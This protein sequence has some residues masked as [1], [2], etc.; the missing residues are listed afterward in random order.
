MSSNRRATLR[1]ASAT[2]ALLTLLATGSVE[3]FASL[4]P[5]RKWLKLIVPG[6][7]R[8]SS[9]W[10]GPAVCG[11]PSGNALLLKGVA[12]GPWATWRLSAAPGKGPGPSQDL[13]A[14]VP[15]VFQIEGRTIPLPKCGT[16]LGR[17]SCPSYL[18]TFPVC[19]NTSLSMAPTNGSMSQFVLERVVGTAGQ[20]YVRVNARGAGC[21]KRY[22]GASIKATRRGCKE[23]QL[24]LFAKDEAST[25]TRWQIIDR[26]ALPPCASPPSPPRPSPPPPRPSPPPPHPSPPPPSPSPPSPSPP[27]PSPSPPPPSPSPPPPSPSP[28][29]PSP[30]P[31]PPS[32]SPP[33]PSP[34][35]PP[36]NPPPPVC[37]PA[38]ATVSLAGGR[39]MPMPDLRTGDSVLSVDWQGRLTYAEVFY[40]SHWDPQATGLYTT[41]VAQ[42]AGP[43]GVVR[44]LQLGQTH[45]LPAGRDVS[46][47]C[48]ALAA[49][50]GNSTTQPALA[51]AWSEASKAVAW[52][53]HTMLMPPQLSPGMVAW[54]RDDAS[55]GVA[56][57]CILSTEQSVE[58]GA[59]TPVVRARGIVVDGV[60]ASTQTD[61]YKLHGRW[62][63]PD[64]VIPTL[65]YYALTPVWWAYK[66]AGPE[67]AWRVNRLPAIANRQYVAANTLVWGPVLLAALGLWAAMRSSV[68][69]ASSSS[70]PSRPALF[71]AQTRRRSATAAAVWA[72][73]RWGI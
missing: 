5:G 49:A 15:V 64:A 3:G 68:G 62:L 2:L 26:P 33:P 47:A 38:H 70:R 21:P 32:P 61:W 72:A 48:A 11:A 18:G 12:G 69:A 44:R 41:V 17:P 23:A 37:F 24:G 13:A 9:G 35:P 42:E 1:R 7:C 20:F 55:G 36:P 60:V 6:A 4:T 25:Q 53:R 51:A 14:G 50:G 45:Y 63:L 43:A 10:L 58:L 19:A 57:A 29:P 59:Y 39:T 28:P 22:L 67:L 46:G 52:G 56:P 8:A 31:P 16:A 65:A 40:W 27:P 54:V 30:S 71:R 66:L 34:S 73:R